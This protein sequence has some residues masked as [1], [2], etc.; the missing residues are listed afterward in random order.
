M[1]GQ[2][3]NAQIDVKIVKKVHPKKSNLS[4]AVTSH[5]TNS[6]FDYVKVTVNSDD[7][8]DLDY[9]DDVVNQDDKNGSI[10]DAFFWTMMRR[11]LHLGM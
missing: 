7:E 9:V 8:E 3:N 5:I 10:M 2:N 6:N 1:L 4:N 11:W